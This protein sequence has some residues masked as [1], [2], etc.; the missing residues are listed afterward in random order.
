MI[1][2]CFN[3]EKAIAAYAIIFIH[4]LFPSKL[5]IIFDCIGRFAVPL[6]FI[7]S[8]YFCYYNDE[9][10]FKKKMNKKNIAYY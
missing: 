6:F 10:L 2:K 8:G 9:Y 1:N 4:C 3:I 7:I 5:G